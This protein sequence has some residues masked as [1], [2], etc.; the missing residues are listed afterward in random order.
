MLRLAF[1][2]LSRQSLLQ[3]KKI[4]ELFFERGLKF[5]YQSIKQNYYTLDQHRHAI[6]QFEICMSVFAEAKQP[7]TMAGHQI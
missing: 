4:Y 6:D 5:F 7:Q 1:K 3:K 2:Q